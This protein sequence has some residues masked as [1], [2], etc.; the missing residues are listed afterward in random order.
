VSIRQEEK[1]LMVVV[2]GLKKVGGAR[3]GC[4]L[5]QAV[6]AFGLVV[7]AALRSQAGGQKSTQQG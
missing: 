6:P 4:E 2:M 5:G 1:E 3:A 7:S